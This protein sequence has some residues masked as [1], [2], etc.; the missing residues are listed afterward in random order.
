MRLTPSRWGVTA[1]GAKDRC[2]TAQTSWGT[3]SSGRGDGLAFLLAISPR[4]FRWR[5]VEGGHGIH[6]RLE[7]P[8]LRGVWH[9]LAAA[10]LQRAEMWGGGIKARAAG[11]V[12]QED[13]GKVSGALVIDGRELSVGDQVVWQADETKTVWWAGHERRAEA[14]RQEAGR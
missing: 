5:M 1:L 2:A 7:G 6:Y 11:V 8:G 14:G 10:G 9:V 13:A 12:W 3:K 4:R